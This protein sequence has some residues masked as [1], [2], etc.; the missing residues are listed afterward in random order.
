[1]ITYASDYHWNTSGADAGRIRLLKELVNAQQEDINY[2]RDQLAEIV[3]L[4]SETEAAKIALEALN[5][6]KQ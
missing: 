6:Y 5:R 2:L 3:Y 4:G 1:M